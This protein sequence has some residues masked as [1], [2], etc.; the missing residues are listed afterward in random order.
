MPDVPRF[1]WGAWRMANGRNCG[2]HWRRHFRGVRP[3][4]LP[5]R[6]Q[7]WG[8]LEG[9]RSPANDGALVS[10]YAFSVFFFF[11]IFCFCILRLRSENHMGVSLNRARNQSCGLPFGFPFPKRR[12][13]EVKNFNNDPEVR[14]AWWSLERKLHREI[15][16]A[17]PNPGHRF[18]GMLERR[19]K[20]HAVI[21]QNLGFRWTSRALSCCLRSP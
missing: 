14:A 6:R 11:F 12:S 9:V 21:T 2:A 13:A 1:P 16:A 8:D 20:L 4:T 5:Q 18:F 15:S 3:H 10:E 17:E 19:G 7:G